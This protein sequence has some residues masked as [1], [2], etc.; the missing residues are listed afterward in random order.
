M[1]SVARRKTVAAGEEPDE[2]SDP[3]AAVMF[4]SL[5]VIAAMAQRWER[6]RS[7]VLQRSDVPRRSAW[8]R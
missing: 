4:A 8:N 2:G 6:S 7:T 1:D 3:T 5:P